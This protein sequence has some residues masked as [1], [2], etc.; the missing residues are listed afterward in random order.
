MAI[1]PIVHLNHA[2]RG[3]LILCASSE[4]QGSACGVAKVYRERRMRV[5]GCC[6]CLEIDPAAL[7][8]DLLVGGLLNRKRKRIHKAKL[9][10]LK[11]HA[12][13]LF[14]ETW[15]EEDAGTRP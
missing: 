13:H 4:E 11:G 3:R 5:E 9:K 6:G 7:G 15:C 1:F 10:L 2:E 12:H 8:N 14:P